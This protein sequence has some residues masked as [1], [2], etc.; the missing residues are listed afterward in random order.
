M[1][2][3]ISIIL[4]FIFILY[5]YK[6]IN[7]N[8]HKYKVEEIENLLTSEECDLLI[9][10]AKKVGLSDSVIVNNDLLTESYYDKGSRSSKTVWVKDT[11]HDIALKIAKLS[12]KL[13]GLPIINQES[14]QIA[15]Y[16][17]GGKFNPHYDACNTGTPEYREKINRNAGQRRVTLLIYLNDTFEGGETVFNKIGLIIKPKKGKGILFWNTSETEEILLNSMHCGEP[18][19][20]GEKWIC[21]KWTHV[22]E[23]PI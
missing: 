11:E 15:H 2:I 3:T 20:K 18:V 7:K 12:E 10:H 9:S 16:N 6:S 23:Y 4:I 14:L 17:E 21:T 22:R 1:L 19:I 13:S 5:K 8:M